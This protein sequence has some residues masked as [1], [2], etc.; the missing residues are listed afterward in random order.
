ME[1]PLDD[2]PLAALI[3]SPSEALVA[4]PFPEFPLAAAEVTWNIILIYYLLGRYILRV[5]I[6]GVVRQ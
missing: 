3:L 4:F 1:A 5:W 6:G 2:L